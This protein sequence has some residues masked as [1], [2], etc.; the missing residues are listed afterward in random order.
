M[1]L[2]IRI[3]TTSRRIAGQPLALVIGI[4]LLWVWLRVSW[5]VLDAPNI[6]PPK[7]RETPFHTGNLYP[8]EPLFETR[9]APARQLHQKPAGLGNHAKLAGA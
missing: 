7:M 3:D 4:V 8:V 6:R 9:D 5:L 2:P 1:K